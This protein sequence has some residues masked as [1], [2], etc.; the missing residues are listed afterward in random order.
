MHE[1]WKAGAQGTPTIVNGSGLFVGNEITPAQVG[2]L[3]VHMYQQPAVRYEY[4]SHLAIAGVD[5]TLRRRMTQRPARGIVRAKTGTLNDVIALSGYAAGP[6]HTLA[7][8]IL[9]NGVRGRQGAARNFAD[10]IA[11]AVAAH[12]TAAE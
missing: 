11:A 8:S 12:V 2:A 6:E 5:G 1:F 9:C 7:F 4:L 3:L 10:E